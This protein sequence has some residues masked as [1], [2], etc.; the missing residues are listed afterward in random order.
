VAK[1]YTGFGRGYTGR[2][3]HVTGGHEAEAEAA[4]RAK[5][6]SRL[7][8]FVLKLLGFK[9]SP[10]PPPKPPAHHSPRG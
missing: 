3:Y 5:P 8:L 1:K 4:E 6:P 7:G 2:S 9:G 10:E